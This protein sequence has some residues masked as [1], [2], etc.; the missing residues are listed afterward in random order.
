MMKKIVYCTLSFIIL[1]AC[2]QKPTSTAQH[3]ETQQKAKAELITQ[4]DC[5]ADTH[6]ILSRISQESSIQ[7]LSAANTAVKKCTPKLNNTQI[8]QLL[9]STDLMYQRFLTT[10]SGDESMEGLNAYGYAKAYPENAKDLGYENAAIIKQTLPQR[11]QYLIDH[12]GKQ[13]IQFLDI[14]EGYFE[15]KQNPQYAVD[16]F[17][18]YLPKAEALFIQRMAKDNSDIL[19]SDAAI[20]IPWQELVERALF[21]EKYIQQ[22]PKSYFIQDAQLLFKEYEYLS[23]MGSDNSDTF[24]FA[25]GHYFVETK[26]VKPALLWLSQQPHSKLSEKAKLFLKHTSNYYPDWKQDE[27]DKQRDSLITLL[28]LTPSDFHR[29]CHRAAL[30][31]DSP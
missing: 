4:V 22:Y 13:Y 2:H 15:L 18:P 6:E 11:D 21:W 23:F 24:G 14:G 7:Q 9:E 30:C 26:E 19:Y 17:V 20:A 16:M 12:I 5:F 28:Q 25:N 1:A 3:H 27:Y 29:D 8:Y 31:K 10:A